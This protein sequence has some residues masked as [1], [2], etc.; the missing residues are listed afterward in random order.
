MTSIDIPLYRTIFHIPHEIN[1]KVPDAN[2]SWY[3]Q[4]IYFSFV[5]VFIHNLLCNSLYSSFSLLSYYYFSLFLALV[6]SFFLFFFKVLW[7][8][9]FSFLVSISLIFFVS[10][11]SYWFFYVDFSYVLGGF[12]L[13]FSRIFSTSYFLFNL[14]SLFLLLYF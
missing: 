14:L 9:Y 5:N 13:C 10:H 6:L 2:N 11:L 1:D 8:L 12:F 4:I 7:T 3:L